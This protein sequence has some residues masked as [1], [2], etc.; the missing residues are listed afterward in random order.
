[1]SDKPPYLSHSALSQYLRC[2]EQYRLERVEKIPTPP[3]WY[4]IGGK[5]VHLATQWMD[6]KGEYPY[7]ENQ[8]A[9]LWS[10]A[11][12]Q[13]IAEAFEGWPE[14]DEWLQAG[15]QGRRQDYTYWDMRGLMCV[16]AWHDWRTDP[17]RNLVIDSIE[18]EIEVPL[19]SGIILKGYIDR[20]FRD[21]DG[22]DRHVLDIKSGSKRPTNPIQL[23]MYKIG[24]ELKHPGL[25]V[26]SGAWWMAKDGKEFV[27]KIDHITLE[28]LD[29]WA[30]A[31]YRGVENDVFI[32]NPGDACFFCAVKD[33]CK[34][35]GG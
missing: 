4:F 14:D 20:V 26:V 31:Y 32:P 8:L 23:G 2:G 10:Q 21:P 15:R 18:E 17:E 11:Y 1:M 27:Q 12:D 7:S 25:K 30:R 24:Y 29:D 19:P 35:Y 16:K 28:M 13:E 34:A 33:H 9:Y 5:A 22:L 6:Q 3:A